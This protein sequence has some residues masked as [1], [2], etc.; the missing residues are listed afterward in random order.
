MSDADSD[1][2]LPL[3]RYCFGSAEFDQSRFDLLVAGERVEV[4]RKPLEVLALLLRHAGE[5]VTREE[6]LE[7][8]WQ[9]RPTVEH[10]IN[11]ALAKLRTALGTANAEMILTQPRVGYR[12]QGK[13]ERIPVRLAAKSDLS[14]AEGS[15]VPLRPNFLLTEL[16]DQSE[17]SEV[18]I[19]VQPKSG[20]RRV[21]KF[22]R[23]EA[24]LRA[25]KREA[26][27]QRYLVSVFGRREDIVPVI[28]WNFSQT[29]FFLESAFGGTNLLKWAAGPEQPLT[30]LTGVQRVALFQQICSV[31]A[32]AHSVGVLHKDIKPTNVL[33][34]PG[35]GEHEWKAALADF[36]SASLTD[37]A[38]LAELGITQ[39]GHTLQDRPDADARS[40]TLLYAAPELLAGAPSTT[41]SDVYA[42]GILL[43][44][45]VVGDI[46][47]PLHSGWQREIADELLCADIADATDGDP[48]RRLAG[49]AELRDRLARIEE[50]RRI[51][52]HGR[53]EAKRQALEGAQL[54]RSRA[55]RPWIITSGIA[56]TLGLVV[57]VAFYMD[58]RR[59]A[60]DAGAEAA[61][62]GMQAARA[63]A[64]AMRAD[65]IN[66]FLNDDILNAADPGS[67]GAVAN[68]RMLD[69]LHAAQAKLDLAVLQD[70]ATR[71][72][73]R[74]ALAKSYEALSDVDDSESELRKVLDDLR[75]ADPADPTRLQA[76]YQR[77]K[78]LI[79]MGRHDDARNAV[80]EAD[81]AAGPHL[82]DASV[83]SLESLTAHGDY[84]HG[85]GQHAQALDYYRRAERLLD[86]IA[87]NDELEMAR[88][89]VY[90]ADSLYFL[91]RL[92]ES[93]RTVDPYRTMDH[94]L[95]RIG[96]RY[97]SLASAIEGRSLAD[98]GRPE[99]GDALLTEALRV[100]KQRLGPHN[101]FTLAVENELGNNKLL[102]GRPQEA[103]PLYRDSFD[104]TREAFGADS[105]DA[106]TAQANIGSIELMDGN[107]G[108][109][110]KDLQQ[111]SDGV[112]RKAGDRFPQL[113]EINLLLAE[114]LL[115]NHRVT[116]SASVL[117]SLDRS[118]PQVEAAHGPFDAQIDALRGQ[119]LY[120]QGQH[121]QAL[122]LVRDAIQRME[123]S[124][125]AKSV[126]D[127]YRGKLAKLTP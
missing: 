113:Q 26:T 105:V 57:S 84:F 40:V 80:E 90:E 39:L 49:A 46:Q 114:A 124:H 85:A 120:A 77:V 41:Q 121:E 31:V 71:A 109:A 53:R 112:R 32:A 19:G 100:M 111:A 13:L 75:N 108:A 7:Q 97:W 66:R 126:L 89:R 58:A 35:A 4:Q 125:T 93:A 81:R 51:V 14:L 83:V 27:L 3:Y 95:E 119:I 10:V 28:D 73:I 6:L 79:E 68:P 30:R 123:A 116:E 1:A 96:A 21:Y 50:R 64:Q 22:S 104:A 25:L 9:N 55:R 74:L 47:R 98:G 54:Q 5:V 59:A 94:A 62:A 24:G 12:F 122:A 16:I 99:E 76:Q 103:M 118:Y 115:A 43:Y 127:L 110:L 101:G 17:S 92:D 102:L 34:S 67:P 91:N 117:D 2:D 37:P 88:L 78:V 82:Q 56:L 23:S 38:R 42:L 107:A 72:S 86:Q 15:M 48:A 45:L 61:R 87:P 52:E 70:P 69:V 44:Q 29:P 36:G 8:V 20:E 18:W 65:A 63:E 60:R 11:N 33:V 106:L